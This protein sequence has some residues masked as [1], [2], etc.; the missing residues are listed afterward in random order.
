MKIT[1]NSIYLSKQCCKEKRDDLL[2]M[3]EGE[4]QII[5]PQ[6]VEDIQ[7]WSFILEFTCFQNRKNN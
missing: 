1:K 2:F 5:F 7:V 3:E 4:K 6:R